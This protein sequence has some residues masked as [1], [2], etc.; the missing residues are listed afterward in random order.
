MCDACRHAAPTHT[1]R[2]LGVAQTIWGGMWL[3]VNT[4]ACEKAQASECNV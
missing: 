1:H 4:Y 3:E 2:E